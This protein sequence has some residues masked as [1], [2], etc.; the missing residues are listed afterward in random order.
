MSLALRNE[1]A[2]SKVRMVPI[3]QTSRLLLVPKPRAP[4]EVVARVPAR[5]AEVAMALVVQ[6]DAM[7]ARLT[8]T[9]SIRLRTVLLPASYRAPGAALRLLIPSLLPYLKK[10][11]HRLS[12]HL[13]M[14]AHPR[15]L[16][17]KIV[18]Q[19]S[20]RFGAGMSMDTPSATLVV[21]LASPPV[22]FIR[23]S[24]L[25]LTHNRSV[26]Q[27]SRLLSPYHHEKVHH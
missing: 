19:R 24:G 9:V 25:W 23:L 14:G 13:L 17:V 21:R 11:R 2:C 10:R 4:R 8:T 26:L 1:I 5:E 15:W 12:L 27:A 7:A 3:N 6:R 16:P 20:L 18:G 22:S